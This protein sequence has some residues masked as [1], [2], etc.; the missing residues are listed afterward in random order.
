MSIFGLEVEDYIWN[1]HPRICLIA[2]FCEKTKTPKF[3]I[4]N[5]FFEY[6]WA[7]ISKNYCCIWNQLLRICLFAKFCR[8]TKMP[9]FGNENALFA[10]FWPKMHYLSIFGREFLKKVL[11]Y[12]KSA[13]SNLPNCK[14]SW[15][16]EVS[17][18][19]TK[20]AFFWAKI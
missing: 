4:K 10:Y 1:H 19:E 11:S 15:N 12:L 16:N 8:K 6:F 20:R 7:R 2:K 5:A 3:R 18:F 9:K 17:K 14:I 13:S